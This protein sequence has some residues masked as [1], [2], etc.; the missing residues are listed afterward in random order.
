MPTS[1]S[2]ASLPARTSGNSLRSFPESFRFGFGGAARP[3]PVTTLGWRRF[4]VGRWVALVDPAIAD[5]DPDAVQ[6]EQAAWERHVHRIA[7][8]FA[9]LDEAHKDEDHGRDGEV[10]GPSVPVRPLETAS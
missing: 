2:Y 5:G 1:F 6:P 8:H 7:D 4:A 3:P 10:A 9:E